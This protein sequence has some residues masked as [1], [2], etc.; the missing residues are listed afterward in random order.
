MTDVNEY[1]DVT[2][3]CDRLQRGEMRLLSEQQDMRPHPT[4]EHSLALVV[5]EQPDRVQHILYAADNVWEAP[6]LHDYEASIQRRGIEARLIAVELEDIARLRAAGQSNA[7]V[8][9]YAGDN[10]EQAQEKII[11]LVAAA[12]RMKASDVHFV[13]EGDADGDICYIRIRVDGELRPYRQLPARQGNVL[14]RALFGSMSQVTGATEGYH[15]DKPQDAR[16]LP[17]YTTHLGLFGAR[18][19]TRPRAPGQ[20]MV[21]RLLHETLDVQGGL[22]GLGYLP[23]QVELMR[24]FTRI[25][26][27]IVL[28]TGPTGSGKSNTMK[29]ALQEMLEQFQFNLHLLT[30]EDPPEYRI[31]G[32]NQTPL[33]LGGNWEVDIRSAMRCD[34]DVIMA[35]EMRDRASADAAFKFAETGH[36]F[37]STLHTNDATSAIERLRHMGVPDVLLLDPGLMRGIVAQNLVQKLCPH[38]SLTYKEAREAKASGAVINISLNLEKRLQRLTDLNAIRFRRPGGCPE[39]EWHGI[40]GR[41]PVAE[42]LVPNH[43]LFDVF[44]KEG[45][46]AARRCWLEEM[47]ARSKVDHLIFLINQGLVDPAHGEQAVAPLD[48]D[49]RSLGID[50]EMRRGQ[51]A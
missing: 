2:H 4:L 31:R 37:W 13:T 51:V 1:V 5:M 40:S 38:C 43:R 20:M 11:E 16:L 39:C 35:G 6:L 10:L 30:V 32:A 33:T 45:K 14:M 50:I 34:P 8:R 47:G 27:G 36:G 41:L 21:L 3:V 44:R 29:E 17:E 49:E 24:T 7:G 15:P 22:E 26:H 25:S 46:L 42:I 48:D 18:V 19:T 28:L 9:A 23:E 12:K